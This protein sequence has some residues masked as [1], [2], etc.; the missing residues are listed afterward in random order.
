MNT[1]TLTRIESKKNMKGFE[2]SV[3]GI[4]LKTSDFLKS[5]NK[6]TDKQGKETER[7][8]IT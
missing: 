1:L 6:H 7:C 8:P 4:E 3:L 5:G 2:W